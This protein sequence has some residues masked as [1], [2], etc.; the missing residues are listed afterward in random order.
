MGEKSGIGCRWDEPRALYFSLALPEQ[1]IVCRHIHLSR[2]STMN[3][4]IA[5]TYHLHATEKDVDEKTTIVAE[6]NEVVHKTTSG[7][8]YV[9]RNGIELIPT[10]SSDQNDPLVSPVAYMVWFSF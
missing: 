9:T 6:H 10:P 5:G 4:N 7:A 3:D 2:L 1:S 8:V